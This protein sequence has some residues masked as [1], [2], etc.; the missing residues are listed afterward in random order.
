MQMAEKA[1]D[2]MVDLFARGTSPAEIVQ[3][4]P[5][6]AA[7]DRARYLLQRNKSGDLTTEEAAELERL[8]EL[9]DMM[10]LVKARARAYAGATS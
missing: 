4:R 6:P 1:Y 5:S 8:G 3:F 2:E 9:E 7:Q 10:Q